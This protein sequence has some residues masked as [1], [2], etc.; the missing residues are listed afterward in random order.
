MQKRKLV[1][2]WIVLCVI[3]I[4]WVGIGLV[5]PMFSSML[6]QADTPFFSGE[7]SN[8]ARSWILGILLGSLSIAQF[9]SGPILGALSDQKGRKPVFLFSLLIGICGYLVSASGVIYKSLFLLIFGRVIV[10]VASGNAGVVTATI[11]DLSTEENKAKNFG[12]YSMASGMGF[13]VGPFLGGILSVHGYE[14]PFLLSA[15]IVLL[16][17]IFIYFLFTETHLNRKIKDSVSVI[18]RIGEGWKNF[19][20]AFRVEGLKIFFFATLMFCFGWSF[21]Y[22]FIPVSWIQDWSFTPNEV[23]FAYAYGAVIFAIG[24]GGLIRPLVDRFK[25]ATLLSFSLFALGITIFF[26]VFP[27]P[28]FSIWIY[29]IFINIFGSI[30]WPSFTTLVSDYAPKDAQG[31]T[32]GLYLSVQSVAFAFSPLLAGPVLAYGAHFTILTGSIA[33]LCAGLLIRL[34]LFQRARLR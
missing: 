25:S 19:K 27:L 14:V 34:F 23:G 30:A 31:E 7:L 5:Y 17:L 33:M 8:S 2:F 4:D 12:L 3:F 21:F 26:I 18:K 10:G 20:K 11:A 15:M 1:S 28:R 29:L 13:A 22:E 6:F 24:S 32:L 9:F 16:N